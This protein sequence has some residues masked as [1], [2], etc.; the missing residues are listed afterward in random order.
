MTEQQAFGCEPVARLE[1]L[2]SAIYCFR[3]CPRLPGEGC[4][5]ER[6]RIDKDPAF[7]GATWGLKLCNKHYAAGFDRYPRNGVGGLPNNLIFR[8]T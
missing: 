2:L 7:A 8:L 1:G 4:G 5:C 6:F 3:E